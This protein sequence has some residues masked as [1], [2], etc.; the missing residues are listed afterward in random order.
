MKVQRPLC[1]YSGVSYIIIHTVACC[2][3][4]FSSFS[5]DFLYTRGCFPL[6]RSGEWSWRLIALMMLAMW[7]WNRE[8]RMLMIAHCNLSSRESSNQLIAIPFSSHGVSY[9]F[10][11][12]L[13]FN[14]GKQQTSFFCLRLSSIM[15]WNHTVVCSFK[16][17]NES[18]IFKTN[19]F[20]YEKLPP[21]PSHLRSSI[22]YIIDYSTSL[23]DKS[24]PDIYRLWTSSSS[25]FQIVAE[26]KKTT[27][28]NN[29]RL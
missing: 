25:T 1:W 10:I 6:W 20:G 8:I 29:G 12:V 21:L 26:G 3:E 13:W 18:A 5:L 16:I 14:R 15:N 4:V 17:N 19:L 2:A 9:F 28:Y 24:K 7:W 11:T 22:G 23:M 27:T